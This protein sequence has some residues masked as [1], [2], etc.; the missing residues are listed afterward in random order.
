MQSKWILIMMLLTAGLL[1]S[2]VAPPAPPGPPAAAMPAPPPMFEGSGMPGMTRHGAAPLGNWWKNSEIAQQL[3]LSDTQR[4]QLEK[5]FIEHRMRLIDLQAATEKEEL[6]FQTL[7][8]ADRPDP[9]QVNAQLD[10]LQNARGQ[11]LKEFT[12]MTLSF[13]QILTPE[14]WRKLESIRQQ[15][16]RG[17]FRPMRRPGTAP[18]RAE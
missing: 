18:P 5:S 3:G 1:S 15:R 13:R 17:M 6:K 8:D 4:Q 7:M 11:L 16:G 14:Q 10:Q 9:A 2:Q 12:G